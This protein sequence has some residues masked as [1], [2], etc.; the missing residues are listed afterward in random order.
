MI[1][2]NKIK[3]IKGIFSP[4]DS[5]AILNTLYTSKIN[6]HNMRNF[7]SNERLGKPD[8][9]SVK[10]IPELKE[11]IKT[12]AAILNTAAENNYKVKLNSVVEIE[13]VSKKVSKK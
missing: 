2:K 12:I 3:L 4:E 10:R 13:F 7:S 6:F 1:R 8:A 11:S 5:K 9:L